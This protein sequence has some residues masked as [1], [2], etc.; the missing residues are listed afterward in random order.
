MPLGAGMTRT[1]RHNSNSSES[2]SS[3]PAGH[4]PLQPD[5]PLTLRDGFRGLTRAAGFTKGLLRDTKQALAVH[6]EGAHNVGEGAAI[7]ACNHRLPSDFSRLGDALSRPLSLVDLQLDSGASAKRGHAIPLDGAAPEHPD[8][9]SVLAQ[10][11]LVVVFPEGAMSPDGR[12]HR[13]DPEVAWLT[14]TTHAPVVPVGI[15]LPDREGL[16]G[17]ALSRVLGPTITFGEPLDFSRYWTSPALSDALDGVL[18]RGCTA[19]IMAAIAG[20]SGQVYQDDTPG[21]AKDLI[22]E[23]RHHEA[24][25]R[26]TRYPT[27]W[28]QRRRAAIAREELRAADNRDLE[29]AAAEAAADL[30]D[31]EDLAPGTAGH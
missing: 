9:V 12:L 25:Q 11:G 22:R 2:A 6:V 20:L 29:R 24:Q 27:Q 21:Q 28:E 26:S 7:L 18:L 3:D 14:L 31:P 10:G 13:G 23:Q 5:S 1:P 30:T 15:S 4:D 16:S 17:R 19:E 8:A